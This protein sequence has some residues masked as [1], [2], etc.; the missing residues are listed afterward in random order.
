MRR[1]LE[2]GL[3]LTSCL[4]VGILAF[5]LLS[6]RLAFAD[7]DEEDEDDK[8]HDLMEKTHEGRKSPWKRAVQAAHGNPIDWA[9]INQAL[10]RLATMSDALVTAKDK[11]VRD[12]A[13]GYVSAV[14][15]LA[16]Q[17]NKRDAVRARAA[18][19]ALSNSCADCH[20]KG[21]PGGKL[22]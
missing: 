7:K 18:L 11:E 14:K 3:P 15:E 6:Q 13:D 10:P 20:F 2:S 8:V 9:T 4:L 1:A 19:A 12:A 21:G 5:G 22:D 16:V 17:A